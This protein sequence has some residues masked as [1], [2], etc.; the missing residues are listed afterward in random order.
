MPFLPLQLPEK[1]SP[2]SHQTAPVRRQITPPLPARAASLRNRSPP[3]RRRRR[4]LPGWQRPLSLATRP[5]TAGKVRSREAMTSRLNNRP[6]PRTPRR[7]PLARCQPNRRHRPLERTTPKWRQPHR[8]NGRFR[9]HDPWQRTQTTSLTVTSP[10]PSAAIRPRRTR[11]SNLGREQYVFRAMLPAA[12]RQTTLVAG[13]CRVAPS[14]RSPCW[15]SSA[16]RYCRSASGSVVE[17]ASCLR[18]LVDE[19]W[20]TIQTASCTVT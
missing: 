17:D 8:L 6:I 14:L 16:S 11:K 9:R 13:V 18:C 5:R 20:P 12:G 10:Q 1:K 4:R 19:P 3:S 7:P 15:P 2:S